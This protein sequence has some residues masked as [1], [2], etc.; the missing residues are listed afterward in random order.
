M[1]DDRTAPRRRPNTASAGA[2][3][4]SI[5]DYRARLGRHVEPRGDQVWLRLGGGIVGAAVPARLGPPLAAV[6]RGFGETGPVL[7]LDSAPSWVF[8]ADANGYVP[9]WE[10]MLSGV[11]VLGCPAWVPVP[12]SGVL[13]ARS[14]WVVPPDARRRWLPTLASIIALARREEVSAAG[15]S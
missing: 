14:R 10:G 6:L 12:A 11:E 15:R 9:G 8:L 3:S 4:W 2:P 1:K 5:A 7:E 13:R